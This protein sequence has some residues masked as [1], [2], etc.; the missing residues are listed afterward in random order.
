MH[1][2][3]CLDASHGLE[4]FMTRV[5]STDITFEGTFLNQDTRSMVE[6]SKIGI[7]RS[8]VDGALVLEYKDM[9]T[10]KPSKL[11]R[12][13]C[14][15]LGRIEIPK[16]RRFPSVLA[17]QI[18]PIGDF[19]GVP[20]MSTSSPSIG[21]LRTSTSGHAVVELASSRVDSPPWRVS[22]RKSSH[23]NDDIDVIDSRTEGISV[24]DLKH[25]GLRTFFLRSTE[26]WMYILTI[27]EGTLQSESNL[28][29][30]HKARSRVDNDRF[31]D[32]VS[33]ADFAS[34]CSLKIITDRREVLAERDVEVVLISVRLCQ[35]KSVVDGVRVEQVTRWRVGFLDLLPFSSIH[36]PSELDRSTPTLSTFVSGLV[37]G[38][39]VFRG[40]QSTNQ[41]G[42]I[43]E[44]KEV[45]ILFAGRV[46]GSNLSDCLIEVVVSEPFGSSLVNRRQLDKVDGG[47][48]CDGVVR[49]GF[50]LFSESKV[51]P[52]L[53]C[54][55]L[56]SMS[57][58]PIPLIRKSR[59]ASSTS[60]LM[61]VKKQIDF[62]REKGGSIFEEPVVR[63]A[64]LLEIANNSKDRNGNGSFSFYPVLVPEVSIPE[65]QV[66]SI[67]NV[68]LVVDS[69]DLFMHA[70]ESSNLTRQTIFGEVLSKSPIEL[71]VA[72]SPFDEGR[73]KVLASHFPFCI[74]LIARLATDIPTLIERCV[75]SASRQL[76]REWCGSS[77]TVDVDGLA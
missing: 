74:P 2:L 37:G 59:G 75:R 64:N 71:F 1:I 45:D 76:V 47:T 19:G 67:N 30:S 66:D 72:T 50:G 63:L 62:V 39:E 25:V 11:S 21:F 15:C 18:G 27:S 49:I 9:F 4:G 36:I 26:V 54:K 68:Y 34:M 7:I 53:D 40:T 57:S 13:Q 10:G 43:Q 14:L 56:C 20:V 52:E 41:I 31:E 6:Q 51:L 77:P 65:D 29:C 16:V 42:G 35:Q 5:V 38:H 70:V 60:Q 69:C 23:N 3:Q 32:L 17:P 12:S 46:K 22:N 28:F 24:N 55:V 44:R 48:W 73:S 61:S 8:A 33:A 58:T